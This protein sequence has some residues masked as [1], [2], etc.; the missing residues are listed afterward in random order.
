M[1][2][3]SIL[4]LESPIRLRRKMAALASER[5]G[6]TWEPDLSMG[7][8]RAAAPIAI[9]VTARTKLAATEAANMLMFSILVLHVTL[10]N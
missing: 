9:Y 6:S 3:N 5:S 10:V 2:G 4:R 7:G 8:R 1:G